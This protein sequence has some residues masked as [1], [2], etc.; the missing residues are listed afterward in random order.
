MQKVPII[1]DGDYWELWYVEVDDNAT[2]S[3]IIVNEAERLIYLMMRDEQQH[4]EETRTNYR[5]DPQGVKGSTTP[6]C[7][8]EIQAQSVSGDWLKEFRLIIPHRD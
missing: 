7:Q 8:I 1:C 4:E 5:V 2:D 3:Q 6:S